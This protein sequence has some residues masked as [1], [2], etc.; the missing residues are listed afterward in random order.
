MLTPVELRFLD[1]WFAARPARTADPHIALVAFEQ[2]EVEAHRETRPNDCTCRS[3]PRNYIAEIIQAV[4]RGGARVVVLDL[5]LE[6][7]CQYRQDGVSAHDGP[8]VEALRA[9][10]ETVLAA[11]ASE[12]T[13]VPHFLKPRGELAG[14]AN[15]QHILG[16]P[17][18]Y[19]PGGVVRAVSLVQT[20]DPKSLSQPE[21]EKLEVIGKTLPPLSA[22]AWAAWSGRGHEIPVPC[23]DEVVECMDKRI[24]TWPSASIY[25][26][27]RLMPPPDASIEITSATP[28]RPSA[29]MVSDSPS[30]R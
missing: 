13:K 22:A 2:P 1:A 12:N 18:L 11:P 30:S 28:K 7:T 21:I 25:V 20:G 23:G 8:L 3:V 16:S 24:P 15:Y 26:M 4:R 9:G 29:T 27:K 5:T 10:G 6:Q 17:L 14:P 19:A